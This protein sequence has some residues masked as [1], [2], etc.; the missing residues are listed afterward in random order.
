MYLNAIAAMYEL[1]NDFQWNGVWRRPGHFSVVDS[2]IW[3]RVQIEGRNLRTF[4]VIF[5]LY[6]TVITMISNIGAFCQYGTDMYQGNLLLGRLGIEAIPTATPLN[7]SIGAI[8]YIS[9]TNTTTSDSTSLS[10]GLGRTIELPDMNITYDY[11][12]ARINSKDLYTA[13]L[14]GL[15]DAAKA[16]M[17]TICTELHA[18]SQAGNLVFWLDGDD[19]A[20]QPLTYE[21][22]TTIFRSIVEDMTLRE[23][24]FAEINFAVL[25]GEDGGASGFIAK[26]P[27]QG[28][29]TAGVVAA[30]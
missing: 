7:T 27:L 24:R 23:R 8:D 1:A 11:V 22:V 28:N 12:G 19:Q 29:D 17:D 18:Y 6:Y 30:K 15:A 4:H 14:S 10:S 13:V 20:T 3:I 25:F 9:T 2:G 21:S 5:A 26:M 16:G